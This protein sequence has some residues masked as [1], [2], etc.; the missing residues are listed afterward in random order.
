MRKILILAEN[1]GGAGECEGRDGDGDS[2]EVIG[3]G[4]GVLLVIGLGGVLGRVDDDDGGGAFL[5]DTGDGTVSLGRYFLGNGLRVAKAVLYGR[6]TGRSGGDGGSNIMGLL[7]LTV[8]AQQDI[9]IGADGIGK[10]IV[11]QGDVKGTFLAVVYEADGSKVIIAGIDLAAVIKGAVFDTGGHSTSLLVG[12]ID[13]SAVIAELT[14]LDNDRAIGS[15]MDCRISVAGSFAVNHGEIRLISFIR[16]STIHKE[17]AAIVYTVIEINIPSTANSLRFTPDHQILGII[18][19]D[20]NIQAFWGSIILTISIDAQIP[21][22][23]IRI[24]TINSD[25]I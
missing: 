7:A 15:G 17:V 2:N 22:L 5:L 3:A 20:G 6:I 10:G 23:E 21:T 1:D 18:N 16:S 9:A 24:V 13:R 14:V 4:G 12:D 8:V 25:I 19:V 11:G